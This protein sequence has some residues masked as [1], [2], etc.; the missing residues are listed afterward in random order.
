[1]LF[2][3][4][5]ELKYTTDFNR[6]AELLRQKYTLDK[7]RNRLWFKQRDL[8][9]TLRIIATAPKHRINLQDWK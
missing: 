1:M 5:H 9:R 7:E 4:R 6:A 2:N 8:E 3:I